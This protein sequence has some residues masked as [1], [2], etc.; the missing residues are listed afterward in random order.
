MGTI[1]THGSLFTGIGGI[2][3]GLERA[4]FMTLYQV[5]SDPYCNAVLEHRWP[6]VDRRLDC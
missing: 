5:E 1:L 2:D 3:L 6:Q 4:G